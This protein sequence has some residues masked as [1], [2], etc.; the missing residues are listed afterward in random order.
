MWFG[1]AAFYAFLIFEIAIT[2]ID[3]N[4]QTKDGTTYGFWVY[5]MVIFASVCF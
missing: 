4:W 2:L 5:G 3:K 1:L